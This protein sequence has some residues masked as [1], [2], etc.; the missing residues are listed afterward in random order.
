LK[1]FSISLIVS[2]DRN[3]H[4][5]ISLWTLEAIENRSGVGIGIAAAIGPSHGGEA[6]YD[7]DCDTDTDTDGVLENL[8]F[9]NELISN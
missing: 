7:S 4:Q 6:D 2:A 1:R 5:I 3:T 8:R 9:A